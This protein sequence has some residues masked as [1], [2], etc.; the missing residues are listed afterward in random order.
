MQS[1]TPFLDVR[2]FA[3]EEAP[4]RTEES[5]TRPQPSSPFLA[6]YEFEEGSRV[7]PQT[8]EYVSFLNELYDEKFNEVLSNLVDEA[9]GIYETNFASAH[10][11]PPLAGNQAERLLNQHFAPL[12]AEAETMIR[13]LASALGA[14]DPANL[15]ENEV[16]TLVD[17]YHPSAQLAPNFE[18]WLGGLGNIIKKVAK[19]GL[20]LAQKGFS[21]IAKLGLGP[22]LNK[23]LALVK[24]M[25]KRVIESAI[26]KLPPTLQP[27][28]RKLRD[29]LPFLKE[30]EEGEASQAEAAGTFGVAEIQ[31]EF[32]QGAANL[33]F[34]QT[35]TEQDLEIARVANPPGGPDVY[36]VAELELAR[37]RF[38]E[39]L[40]QLK[41]GEDPTPQVENFLPALIPVLKVGLKLGGRK[42]VV[43][44]LAN[45]LGK[46]IQKF[47]GP[48]YAPPLSKAIVDAGL[49]LLQLEAPPRG[50]PGAAASAVASTVEETMRRVANLP[51]YVLDNQELLEGAT[52]RAFEGAAAENLPPM[53]SEE[54]YRKRP[55]LREHRGGFWHPAGRRYKKRLGPKIIA[56]ISPYNVARLETFDGATVG[57]ALEEQ[58]AIAPGEEL[59]AEVHLYEAMPGM[60][61]A[62][63][64][65]GERIIAQG[66]GEGGRSVLH[67]LTPDAATLLM[68]E[69]ELGREFEGGTGDPNAPQVGQRFYSLEIPGK[70]PL[71]VPIPGGRTHVRHRSQSHFTFHFPKNEIIARLY[72][73]EIRAQEIAVKLRQ[74]GHMGVELER[75]RHVID[76]AVNRA[77][78]ANLGRLKIVHG[79]V[80]PGLPANALSRLPSVVLQILRGRLTEW[81][82]KGLADHLQQHAQEFI[83]AAD[84]TA[85]G[86]TLVVTLENPPG[87]RQI[88]EALKG[89][90][91]SLATLKIPEGDPTVKLKI[92]PGRR[93][94]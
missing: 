21:A 4:I 25:I 62:D 34:A 19:T 2:S 39:G 30:F 35:E 46:L 92:Q 16:D 48:Q 93:H 5:T 36:P 64:V 12:V 60:R 74:H 73:S 89:K 31:N 33:L 69:P 79:A 78:T 66:D 67:P 94:G 17:R 23:L 44:F 3:E 15:S 71:M 54:T 13:T 42:R 53:L 26:N 14:R 8:E 83:T 38:V 72:L 28:A 57:E 51:E 24:P 86:V 18:E 1:Q 87:F 6:V 32:N 27:I 75:L 9:A 50:E 52:L 63:I 85:D 80:I 77:F 22:I 45:F 56:R 20:S 10:Q 55:E 29:K 82:V 84:D 41:E 70:R 49:R 58:Y 61:L 76:R 40:G 91:V 43:D 7:D 81:I 90:G 11:S 47:V 37:E 88:G 59:E 68:D 65:R